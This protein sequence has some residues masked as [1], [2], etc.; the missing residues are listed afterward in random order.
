LLFQLPPNLP[1]DPQRLETF[2]GWLPEGCPAAFEFRHASWHEDSVRRLL[3]A[4]GFGVV[5]AD[6]DEEPAEAPLPTDPGWGYL[7]LRRL[8]YGPEELRAWA[9]RVI[10]TGWERAFVFFKHEDAGAGPRMAEAFGREVE[11]LRSAP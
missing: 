11:L 10:A 5:T 2:L 9:E 7:R 6:T 3:A 4:R 1:A 8:A